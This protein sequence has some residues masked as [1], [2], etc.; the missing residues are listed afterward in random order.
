MDPQEDSPGYRFMLGLHL[1]E[2]GNGMVT[3]ASEA[4]TASGAIQGLLVG[5]QWHQRAPF[6]A[7]LCAAAQDLACLA[8]LILDVDRDH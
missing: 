1:H 5:L 2:R 7:P 3:S 4:E 6:R 8:Y